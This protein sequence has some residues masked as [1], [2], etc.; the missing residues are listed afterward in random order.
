MFGVFYDHEYHHSYAVVRD[1]KGGMRDLAKR[2]RE[3]EKAL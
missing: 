3:G 2:L 1:K